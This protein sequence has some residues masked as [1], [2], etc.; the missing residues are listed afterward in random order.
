MM[1]RCKYCGSDTHK[2]KDCRIGKF[3]RGEVD[4]LSYGVE[5][6]ASTPK[7][8]ETLFKAIE[9]IHNDKVKIKEGK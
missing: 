2:S 6:D 4:R 7:E 1:K 9:I 8:L 3:G 5:I